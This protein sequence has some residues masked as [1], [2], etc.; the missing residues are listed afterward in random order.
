MTHFYKFNLTH[1]SAPTYTMMQMLY[2]CYVNWT[3]WRFLSLSQNTNSACVAFYSNSVDHCI[4]FGESKLLQAV[5]L[6]EAACLSR[7]ILTVVASGLLSILNIACCGHSPL[8]KCYIMWCLQA[9]S[10]LL[11]FASHY[12]TCVLRQV[13]LTS[14]NK[15]TPSVRGRIQAWFTVWGKCSSASVS[16]STTISIYLAGQ[17][18]AGILSDS[19]LNSTPQGKYNYSSNLYFLPSVCYK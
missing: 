3:H 13:V 2:H 4:V 19:E 6:H 15:V 12:H 17:S 8:C 10:T 5:F 1:I 7:W 9:F 11:C 18:I 16:S 14:S